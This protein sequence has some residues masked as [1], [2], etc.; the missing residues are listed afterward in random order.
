MLLL[1]A[2]SQIPF[3]TRD[4]TLVKPTGL[5]NKPAPETDVS[6]K[7][8]RFSGRSVPVVVGPEV[9]DRGRRITLVE[10]PKNSE[11]IRSL[12]GL[13]CRGEPCATEDR[14]PIEKLHEF[15]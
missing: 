1:Q 15:V 4:Q 3:L 9:V 10:P 7:A 5:E 2:I 12:H 11:D 13:D 6:A 14:I 8:V